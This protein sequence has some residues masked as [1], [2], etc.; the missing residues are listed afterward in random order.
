M[1]II[2]VIT[3]GGLCVG[4]GV[5]VSMCVGHVSHYLKVVRNVVVKKDRTAY[6]DTPV[7]L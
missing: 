6:G 7:K 5:H 4:V 3:K 2:L 1:F